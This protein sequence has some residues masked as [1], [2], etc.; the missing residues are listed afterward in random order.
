MLD[1]LLPWEFSPSWMLASLSATGLYL[2]GMSVIRAR[3]GSCGVWRPLAFFLGVAAMYAVT[4]THY[5]YFA[6]YMFF[7]HR[8]QHL[9]LHHAA[10][11]LLALAV[12]WPVLAAGV[13]APL[14]HP[15]GK[16]LAVAILRPIYRF[17]QHPLV[18]PFLF[19]GL[20]YFWLLPEVHFD[21]MLS[22]DLYQVMNWSMAL[23][24]LL[25]WWLMLDPRTKA[26]GGLGYGARIAALIAI[27]P[28]QIILGAY[29]TFSE[30][31]IFDVY[32]VC[33]RAWPL[34]PLTD[35]QLGGL[36]TWVPAAMMSMVG[37][38]I[39]LGYLLRGTGDNKTLAKETNDVDQTTPLA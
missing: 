24:G 33:G 28:P 27:M 14:K 8:G 35:Q 39:V 19:V 21:A 10:P 38:L 1:Y 13:P 26:E 16:S 6:Q 29:I 2:R 9:V 15:P 22:R 11:F 4:H 25:F 30:R 32:E 20:I 17:L 36:L 7:T 31:V 37:C 12:P 18:A 34:M 23:D 5:D 3:G